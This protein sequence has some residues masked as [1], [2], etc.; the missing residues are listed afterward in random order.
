MTWLFFAFKF[1]RD[2]K[3]LTDL[4]MKEYRE[5]ER[6]MIE[7]RANT[8]LIFELECRIGFYQSMTESGVAS[9][10]MLTAELLKHKQQEKEI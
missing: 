5:N 9:I 8:K 3:Y 2:D 6:L 10:K 1:D 7:N 4:L